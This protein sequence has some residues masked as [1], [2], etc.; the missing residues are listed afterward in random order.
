MV[1]G[2]N[3]NGTTIEPLL[4]RRGSELHRDCITPDGGE[5]VTGDQ[6]SWMIQQRGMEGEG[7]KRSKQ[8]RGERKKRLTELTERGDKTD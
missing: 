7:E 4:C 8:K 3:A 2:A 6:D 1:S 5:R